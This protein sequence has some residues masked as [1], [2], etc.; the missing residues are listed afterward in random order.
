MLS[1]SRKLSSVKEEFASRSPE[2]PGKGFELSSGD[3]V[4]GMLPGVWLPLSPAYACRWDRSNVKPPDFPTTHGL[5]WTWGSVEA[6]ED[7]VSSSEMTS[8]FSRLST[9]RV[10]PMLSRSSSNRSRRPALPARA[11]LS[12]GSSRRLVPLP[13]GRIR[14]KL[15]VLTVSAL[16]S[17]R[18]PSPRRYS[19]MRVSCQHC[20]FEI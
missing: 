18:D 9:E 8:P 7:G 5:T 14:S 16:R 3:G 10:S 12:R 13:L 15:Q 19:R 4:L 6:E 11:L 17:G 2:L 20:C 1:L